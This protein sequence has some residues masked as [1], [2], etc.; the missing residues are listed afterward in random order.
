MPTTLIG[1]SPWPGGGLLIVLL[2]LIL[3]IFVVLVIDFFPVVTEI[4]VVWLFV[5]LILLVLVLIEVILI[6]FVFVSV[7]DHDRDLI[8]LARI[9]A[10]AHG[11][12]LLFHQLGGQNDGGGG[13]VHVCLL[14]LGKIIE[15]IRFT[16][17]GSSG[18]SQGSPPT[19]TSHRILV[20]LADQDRLQPVPEEIT[21]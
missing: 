20:S 1:F 21:S 16:C 8:R 7:P 6:L 19:D 4:V 5:L 9:F 3:L 11:D 2:L 18:R 13:K 17:T 10:W 12:Y 14:V 15:L